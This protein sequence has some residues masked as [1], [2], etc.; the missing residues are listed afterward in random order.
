MVGIVGA[1]KQNSE[2]QDP[3]EE[4]PMLLDMTRSDLQGTIHAMFRELRS[5]R[6]LT[7]TFFLVIDSI[8]THM[9]NTSPVY[10][11]SGMIEDSQMSRGG[12]TRAIRS[13][14]TMTAEKRHDEPSSALYVLHRKI[15]MFE[16]RRDK[17]PFPSLS[18]QSSTLD[19]TSQASS[20]PPLFH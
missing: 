16:I 18:H 13:T 4:S 19:F 17:K 11:C 20:L 5:L 15:Y 3:A 14:C 12:L 6:S 8:Q 10:V 1:Q 2:L 7:P 9:V